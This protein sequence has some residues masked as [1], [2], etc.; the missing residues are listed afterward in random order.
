MQDV[1]DSITN[2]NP[3]SQLLVVRGDPVLLLPELFKRWKISHIVFEKDV[4]GYARTRDKQVAEIA[5]KAGVE[6]LAVHGHH[7]Y[8]I[9]EAVKKH[10]GKPIASLKVL[11][12][13]VSGMPSPDKPLDRPKELPSPIMPGKSKP[14]DLADA[15]REIHE[16]LHGIPTYHTKPGPPKLDYNS[17]DL[18]GQR[19]PDGKVTC[20]DTINGPDEPSSKSE[21]RFTVPTLASL[22][23]DA[24]ACGAIE[25]P[26]VKGGEME[27]LR[28][29]ERLCKDQKEYLATFA[30]PKTSPSVDTSEPSTTLLSPFIKFGCISIRQLWH[31][32]KDAIKDYKGPKS[33][34]PENL[35]GQL[36][37]REMYACAE[38]ATGDAYQVVRGNR[39]SRYMDWYLPNHYEKDGTPIEPRPRG[40]DV[41]E[42]RLE[43]YRAGQ[44]G[45]PW[46]D[47]GI[48]QLRYTGW[49]HHLMRHSLASFL[50]RGQCWI[51]WERGAEMFEEWLLDWDPNA[52]AGNWMWLSC[53][54]FFS[55]FYRVY[56]L[57]TFGQK[58]DKSGSLIRK[59]CPELKDF[60][61]KFIYAPHTAPMEVQKKAKCIIGQDYPFPI[62]D[63]KE[64]KQICLNRMKACYDAK[65]YGNSKEV[66]D[67]RAQGILRKK[68]GQPD[69]KPPSKDQGKNS[70]IPQWAKAGHEATTGASSIKGN[71]STNSSPKKQEQED[72]D[73]DEIDPEH[74]D[75]HG[76]ESGEENKDAK[77]EKKRANEEGDTDN[78]KGAKRS[79]KK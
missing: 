39:L 43:A 16:S 37:F 48:R 73:D 10:E 50:T 68:H 33:S 55:Q 3:L 11:E 59:Y 25:E 31:D 54:A 4:N 2:V 69:P 29:L 45:F 66:F 7:L 58:F 14:K 57:A 19:K 15:L 34:P 27:A 44:T 28:R 61:D 18:G 62:L 64:E 51:S 5:K 13:V 74:T 35:E 20:Y 32:T 6:V 56:G 65:L 21:E 38:L 52:N 67:G 49:I 75:R 53:S 63:E 9:E 71:S 17:A 1:S 12:S 8:D 41:S 72:E 76:D 78:S 22:G 60:P 79:K 46:I 40:D 24:K 47:A 23:M 77:D 70:K 36:M 26:V 42:K 30:K